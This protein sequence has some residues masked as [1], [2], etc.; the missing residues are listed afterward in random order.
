[1]EEDLICVWVPEIL[2]T[3]FCVVASHVVVDDDVVVVDTCDKL[4]N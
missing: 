1:M 3:R 2:M 4:C